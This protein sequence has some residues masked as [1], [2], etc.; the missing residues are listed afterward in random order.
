[1]LVAW[2]LILIFL[3]KLQ[4][5]EGSILREDF[6]L[7]HY[8]SHSPS[9]PKA[10]KASTTNNQAS[11][12]RSSASLDFV[13]LHVTAPSGSTS[14]L[15]AC[16]LHGEGATFIFN[17]ELADYLVEDTSIHPYELGRRRISTNLPVLNEV[18]SEGATEQASDNGSQKGGDSSAPHSIL[19]LAGPSSS[20]RNSCTSDS[21]NKRRKSSG[22][23][24]AFMVEKRSPVKK[25]ASVP[26]AI[27]AETVEGG[28]SKGIQSADDSGNEKIKRSYSDDFTAVSNDTM[29]MLLMKKAMGYKDDGLTEL[30]SNSA[31]THKTSTSS[32]KKSEFIT[33]LEPTI[34]SE[35]INMSETEM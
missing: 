34:E 11:N 16:P 5:R 14:T 7:Q 33:V 8:T 22:T 6:M 24:K 18:T 26:A 12:K 35:Q 30:T 32:G 31:R 21:S 20:G 27:L 25:R 29:K 2:F 19:E 13:P 17:S 9:S 15:K 28:L 23:V 1:M 4:W 3:A 10:P